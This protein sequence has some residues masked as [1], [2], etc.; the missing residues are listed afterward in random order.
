MPQRSLFTSHGTKRKGWMRTL[1]D[2][3]KNNKI[4]SAL[5]V[6]SLVAAIAACAVIFTCFIGA[7]V[8]PLIIVAGICV[9]VAAVIAIVKTDNT[10]NNAVLERRITLSD[11]EMRTPRFDDDTVLERR[12]KRYD[13]NRQILSNCLEEISKISKENANEFIDQSRK[14]MC[15]CHEKRNRKF[16]RRP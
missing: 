13:L 6:V 4:V 3:V 12:T 11:L 16:K 1:V 15:N 10:N 8:I 5:I 14:Q 2:V 9:A 7:I